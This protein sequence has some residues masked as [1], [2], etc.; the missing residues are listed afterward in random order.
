MFEAYLSS[1]NFPQTI[2]EIFETFPYP[3]LMKIR[4]E[5]KEN[6]V[7]RNG[8][9]IHR[10]KAQLDSLRE[11][12]VIHSGNNMADL[13]LEYAHDR[14]KMLNMEDVSRAWESYF[15]EFYIPVFVDVEEEESEEKIDAIE[16][17]TDVKLKLSDLSVILMDVYLL[18]RMFR[19]FR[20]PRKGGIHHTSSSVFTYTGAFHTDGYALFFT[21][22]LGL[23]P[24]LAIPVK[25]IPED[26]REYHR[27]QY[28]YAH[29]GADASTDKW[30]CL[31]EKHL[32]AIFQS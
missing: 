20:Y 23:M 15:D 19:T 2:D 25:S 17:L 31:Q 3:K 5:L 18:A 6:V 32:G 8:R 13:I 9:Q 11:D 28:L 4:E 7:E 21:K 24:T 29:P 30:R 12:N 10:V 1:N 22:Y 16:S 26:V 14:Y 27:A